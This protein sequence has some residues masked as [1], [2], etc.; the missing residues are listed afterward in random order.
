MSL[1]LLP[2]MA[3]AHARALVGDLD[4]RDAEPDADIAWLDRLAHHAVA[5]WTPTACRAGG[6]GLLLDVTGATHLFGGEERFCRR[7]L[8]FLARLGFTARIAVAGT[9]GA[10]HALARYGGSAIVRLEPGGEAQ[11]LAGLP[12][13]ALRLEGDAANAAARFGLDRIGDLYAMPRA[14]LARRLGMK[15]ITRLDQALGR[16]AEPIVPV[17]PVEAPEVIRRL[18]ESIGTAES[19][20]QVIADLVDDL[21][22]VLIER[23]LG[24]RTAMLVASRVDGADQAI[25]IGASRATRDAKRLVRMFALKI[26]RIDPGLGIE[27]MRLVVPR[28]EPL[29]AISSGT[30]L[31]VEGEAAD[32][33]PAIDQLAG[34]AGEHAVFRL[35]V[36]QSDVPERAVARVSPLDLPAGWPQWKRPARLLRRPE[37]LTQVMALL[38]DHPPRRF[39]WRGKLYSVVAGDGPERIHGEWWRRSN[40]LWAVRDYFR[41]EVEDGQRFWLFRRGDGVEA[42]TGDLSW[43]LHGVFG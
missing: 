19:I 17:V 28:S 16:V 27:A 22:A 12:I 14:P 3:A 32:L 6:D 7:V 26:E 2:G 5:H 35:G 8:T 25:A 15:T 31:S 9:A 38:P 42:E 4:V 10:A 37:Q 29:G 13:A 39:T 20:A 41:V 43:Y 36:E 21:V 40:E 34:R 11:A 30:L 1:G 23:G 33:A 18:L 24:V